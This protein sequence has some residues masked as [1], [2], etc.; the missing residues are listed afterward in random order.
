MGWRRGCGE[1]EAGFYQEVIMIHMMFCGQGTIRYYLH[2]PHVDV[3]LFFE[4]AVWG[5]DTHP[6]P[7]EV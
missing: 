3:L 6:E 5:S 2:L 4:L 7:A 1:E